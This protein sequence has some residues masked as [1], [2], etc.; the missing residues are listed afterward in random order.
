MPFDGSQEDHAPHHIDIAVGERIRLRRKQLKI[1]QVMLGDAIDVSFQQVQKYERA[2]NRVSA[3]M[4]YEIAQAL[5]TTVTSLMGEGDGA[6]ADP[7]IARLLATHGALDLLRSFAE[8]EPNIR[9]AVLNF[10]REAGKKD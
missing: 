2:T 4:L 8:L 3:S 10:T 7:E 6:E 9:Q 5:D 1:T